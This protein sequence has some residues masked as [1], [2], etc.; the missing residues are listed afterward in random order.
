M[1]AGVDNCRF[2]CK[3]RR[4]RLM[5]DEA[6]TRALALALLLAVYAGG[7]L[8]AYRAVS[9]ERHTL[10][11]VSEVEQLA[12]ALAGNGGTAVAAGAGAAARG[13][14]TYPSRLH[15]IL[16]PGDEP[17]ASTA[18]DPAAIAE[19]QLQ[20]ALAA[21]SGDA[22][23]SS[24]TAQFPPPLPADQLRWDA[25][26]QAHVLPAPAAAAWAQRLQQAVWAV[27]PITTQPAATVLLYS[28]PLPHRPLL[29]EA[30]DGSI[31]S[32]LALRDGGLLLVANQ[33]ANSSSS[34]SSSGDGA[35]RSAD[36]H[37]NDGRGAAAAIL[38]WLLQP[39]ERLA[40]HSSKSSTAGSGMDAVEQLR[41]A[42]A[43][44]CAAD[45]AAAVRRFVAGAAAAPR[46][47]LTAAAS[48]RAGEAVRLLQGIAPSGAALQQE[49]QQQQ[50][51]PGP[52]PLSLAAA[53]GAWAAARELQQDA[54]TGAHPAFPPEHSLAVVMPLALPVTLVLAQAA[55]R[56][57]GA[58]R[59]RR[60]QQ[61]LAMAAGQVAAAVAAQATRKAE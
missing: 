24:S 10:P 55:A 51:Q 16:L 18:F 7:A 47:P 40:V 43:A 4:Q 31:S 26:R 33:A 39:L 21:L 44:A 13:L 32:S 9:V 23:V 3:E 30:P 57:L 22:V 58:V 14:C 56:E 45:A 36:Q 46:Q 28:P 52:G 41:H 42:L 48:R 37:T 50:Q 49:Q 1:L 35:A 6:V 27:G 29:Q 17:T 61:G 34:S 60:K 12:A 11:G 38:S 8:Q 15:A 54:D 19:H 59:R 20:P 2:M 25:Q 5:G 53:L